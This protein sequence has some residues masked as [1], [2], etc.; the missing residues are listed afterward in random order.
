LRKQKQV[1]TAYITS[2]L[3]ELKEVQKRYKE[4]ENKIK[5]SEEFIL[6]NHN[7]RNN[8]VFTFTDL[9]DTIVL[10]SN[11]KKELISRFLQIL[12]TDSLVAT[13]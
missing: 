2:L 4:L 8:V 7:C 11:N 3:E 9:L 12:L 1:N 5:S 6:K 10:N 13:K